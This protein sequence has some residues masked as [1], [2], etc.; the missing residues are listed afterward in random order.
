MKRRTLINI[1]LLT[2][3]RSTSSLS[4]CT[5]AY[6]N[7]LSNHYCR[8]YS[9]VTNENKTLR[10]GVKDFKESSTAKSK[11]E[12]ILRNRNDKT[13]QT[14]KTVSKYKT[15]TELP[16]N[17]IKNT[18]F[19]FDFSNPHRRKKDNDES[20]GEDAEDA[21]D[22]EENKENKDEGKPLKKVPPE[23]RLIPSAQILEVREHYK[24]WRA[25]F[26]EDGPDP[27]P[28]SLHE[29]TENKPKLPPGLVQLQFKSPEAPIN[30][31]TENK[32]KDKGEKKLK[33]ILLPPEQTRNYT[34]YIYAM[35][36]RYR[37]DPGAIHKMIR[38]KWAP[39]PERAKRRDVN[40]KRIDM[41]NKARRHAH[42]KVLAERKMKRQEMWKRRAERQGMT[43]PV[44]DRRFKTELETPRTIGGGYQKADPAVRSSRNKRVK[45]NPRDTVS[46]W[47]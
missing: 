27:D 29:Q 46:A 16:K 45:I 30:E 1:K 37:I 8:Y 3:K 26:P 31:R 11:R 38:S 40:P 42:N 22:A 2:H 7:V 18:K 28:E 47:F 32:Q 39:D 12:K 23:P 44:S 24:N 17:I 5:T 35:G 14:K 25:L 36:R 4:G 13:K 10:T 33:K 34:S 41:T 43:M 19:K 15:T 21:E 20:E 9:N 6:Y